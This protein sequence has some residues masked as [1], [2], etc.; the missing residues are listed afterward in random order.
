[1][2]LEEPKLKVMV[3]KQPQKKEDIS[4]FNKEKP[5]KKKVSVRC[6]QC[7]GIFIIEKDE[8]ITNIICPKC[9]KEG[10]IK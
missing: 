4:P 5:T 8:K 6:P 7:R 3:E 2:I 1:M 10:V 9:G